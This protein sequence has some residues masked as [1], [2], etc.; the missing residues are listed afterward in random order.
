[1]G[2]VADAGPRIAGG[3]SRQQHETDEAWH[4][5]KAA[6]ALRGSNPKLANVDLSKCKEMAHHVICAWLVSRGEQVRV[7]GPDV[8]PLI[9]DVAGRVPSLEPFIESALPVLGDMPLPFAYPVRDWNKSD[10]VALVSAGA[11]YALA[12]DLAARE[13]M[14]L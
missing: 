13:G 5:E 9:G 1:M 11:A 14:P 4:L 6:L 10:I 8:L 7:E 12:A 3:A 2:G